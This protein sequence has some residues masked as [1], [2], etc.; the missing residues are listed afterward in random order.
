MYSAAPHRQSRRVTESTPPAVPEAT[1]KRG[2]VDGLRARQPAAVH[3]ALGVLEAV[4]QHGAGVS[5]REIS[6]A[7]DLPRATTYRLLNL[8]VQDEYLVRTPDLRGFALGSKLEQFGRAV[9]PTAPPRAAREII[10]ELRGSI[11]AG[12]HLVRYDA[13]HIVL[14]DIDPDFPLSHPERISRELD[15]SAMGRLLLT[16]LGH[17]GHPSWAV[18]RP[19]SS[20]HAITEHV[21]RSG[22]A[23]QNGELQPGHGCIAVAIRDDHDVLV[24]GLAVSMPGVRVENPAKIVDSLREAAQGLAPLLS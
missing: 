18:V 21:T 2:A 8:L 14:S 16:E 11:R 19:A 24:A 7:L 15:C 22:Y 17:D 6:E 3:S 13:T 20:I 23:M 10:N 5:A 12:V 1:R 4:A 9:M